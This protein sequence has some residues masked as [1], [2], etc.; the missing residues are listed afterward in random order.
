MKQDTIHQ[1]LTD[2]C[3]AGFPLICHFLHGDVI[4]EESFVTLQETNRMR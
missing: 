4:K 3:A 1:I 2:V